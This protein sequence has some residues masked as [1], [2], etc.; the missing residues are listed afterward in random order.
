MKFNISAVQFVFK[1]KQTLKVKTKISTGKVC[2]KPQ[3]D[4]CGFDY[5]TSTMGSKSKIS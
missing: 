2:T 4:N 3:A 1:K 5:T